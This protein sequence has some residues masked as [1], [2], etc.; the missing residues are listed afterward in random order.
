M[1]FAKGGFCKERLLDALGD[2]IGGDFL[3]AFGVSAV[4]S[5]CTDVPSPTWHSRV[6]FFAKFFS[7][8]LKCVYSALASASHEKA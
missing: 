2:H 1:T 8:L 5:P 6:F 7:Q 4:R 3:G